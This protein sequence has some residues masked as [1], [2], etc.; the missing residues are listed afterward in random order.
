MERTN[1]AEAR[2]ASHVAARGA[3]VGALTWGAAGL[4]LAGIGQAYSP[5]YR[6]LTIQFKTYIGMCPAILGG[7]V[8]ADRRYREFELAM[9]AEKRRRIARE[10]RRREEE[11]LD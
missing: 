10:V 11:Y 1:P 7:Y 5:L 9:M 4:V 8:E 6:G 3:L 2:Q